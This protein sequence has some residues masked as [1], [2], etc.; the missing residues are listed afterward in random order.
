MKLRFLP[1]SVSL[2]SL[3]SINSTL[4]DETPASPPQASA[5][6]IEEVIVT[7]SLVPRGDFVSNAPI[8]TVTAEQF[9]LANAVNIENLINSMP[10]VVGG[11]DRTSNFGLGWATADL[12]GLGSNRTLVLLDGR[13]FVPTFAEG[14]TVDLNFIPMG[15]IDRV[16]IL[17]GGASAAYGSDA[18]AGVINFILKDEID[19][20]EFNIGGETF[21]GDEGRLYNF[22]VTNGG[23]F[24]SGRGNYLVHLDVTDRQE[25]NASDREFSIVELEDGFLE[26]GNR[27]LVPRLLPFDDDRAF[28]IDPRLFGVSPTGGIFFP[29]DGSFGPWFPAFNSAGTFFPEV[30]YLQI[31][32]QRTSFMG[33]IDF[34]LNETTSIYADITF[35]TSN[36]NRDSFPA[37]TMGFFDSTRW[38]YTL[39]GNPF[40]NNQTQSA[41]SGFIGDGIDTDGDGIADTATTRFLRRSDEFGKTEFDWTYDVVQV[42]F[43]ITGDIFDNWTYDIFTQYGEVKAELPI[44]PTLSIPRLQQALLIDSEGNCLDPSNG[45]VAANIFG[46]NTLSQEA[47]DFIRINSRGADNTTRQTVFS[48]TLSGN[49]IGWLET[50]AGPIGAALGFEY[51]DREQKNVTAPEVESL[52]LIGFLL[53]P[54][55]FEAEE[56]TTSIFTEVIVPLAA[57]LPG[58]DFLEL[59]VAG[60]LSNHSAKGSFSTYKVALSYYPVPDIQFRVSYNDAVR[61]PGLAELGLPQEFEISAFIDQDPCSQLGQPTPEVADI[62][63]ATGVPSNVVGSEAINA[64]NIGGIPFAGGG[65]AINREEEATTISYGLVWT[66]MSI[67]GLSL[68]VDYFKIEIED[69]IRFYGQGNIL[70]RCYNPDLSGSIRQTDA[71]RRITRA[72]NGE[73]TEVWGGWANVG[74]QGITGIDINIA[75]QYELPLGFLDISYVGTSILDQE[76]TVGQVTEDCA[77][78]FNSVCFNNGTPDLKHRMSINWSYD[79]LT[80]QLVWRYLGSVN[81]GE[82]QVNYVVESLGSKSYLEISGSYDIK[83]NLRIIAGVTNLT[84]EDPPL[85][86]TNRQDFNTLPNLYDIF[87]RAIFAKLKYEIF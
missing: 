4:A 84:D 58:I 8:T 7:G 42:E 13:R 83:D 86:G 68:S 71:C 37:P 56:D 81:D 26:D 16:E 40:L 9:E 55:S 29:G 22:N 1:L 76:L 52:Q 12:R 57:G 14:G 24:G 2:A 3:I 77:G 31:P 39:D 11:Q 6:V 45:C 48:G 36:T 66:P 80:A 59:E 50:N 25:V 65:R 62:C 63:I 28:F 49:T 43:G 73:I 79:R 23:Q 27:G 44:E 15:M 78:Q 87:G 18:L 34:E 33:K 46:S 53:Y 38:T 54:Q 35:T 21:D 51:I 82:E 41:L 19:G 61:V 85:L 10:Q 30:N 32:Q 64:F 74:T 70:E 17:T 72:P 67:D 75:Y 20:W 60:R 69:Y 5:P 47:Q